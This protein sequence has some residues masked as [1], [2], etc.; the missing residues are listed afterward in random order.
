MH[1]LTAFAGNVFM[2]FLAIMNPLANTPVF[3]G[4]TS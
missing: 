2:G 1:D 3:L 4:L